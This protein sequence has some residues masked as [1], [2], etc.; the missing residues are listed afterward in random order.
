MN[1]NTFISNAARKFNV[2]SLQLNKKKT[3]MSYFPC[4][5]VI[6]MENLSH[7]MKMRRSC[8]LFCEGIKMD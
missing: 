2:Q 4:D 6:W 5:I 3:T 8:A 7:D 1:L